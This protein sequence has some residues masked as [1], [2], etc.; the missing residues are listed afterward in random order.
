MAQGIRDIKGTNAIHFIKKEE[1]PVDRRKDVT[2]GRIVVA[3]CPQ[4]KEKFRARLIV[5]GDRIN[6]PFEVSSPTAS[7]E[8]IKLHWCSTI[9]TKGGYFTTDVETFTWEHPSRNQST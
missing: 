5:G 8:T 3:Y 7:L 9:S 4:K 2:Y 6:Y 1:T